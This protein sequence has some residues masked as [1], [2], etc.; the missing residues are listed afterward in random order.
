MGADAF[1][2]IEAMIETLIAETF[3]RGAK[4][5]IWAQDP[6]DRTDYQLLSSVDPRH[7]ISR[8][9]F[10]VYKTL[11]GLAYKR[12]DLILTQAKF[13]VNKLI[14]TFIWH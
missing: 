2:S 9:R 1:I 12:A 6:F 5:V 11:F 3:I 7:R 4:H 14:S 8:A 13:Y 10:L